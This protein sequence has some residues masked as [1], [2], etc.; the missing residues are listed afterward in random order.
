MMMMGDMVQS[1]EKMVLQI[2]DMVVTFQLML[3]SKEQRTLTLEETTLTMDTIVLP[4][5]GAH[6]VFHKADVRVL[7]LADAPF[8]GIDHPDIGGVGPASG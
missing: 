4:F 8:E 7:P 1:P 3:H 6:V 2:Y 5:V